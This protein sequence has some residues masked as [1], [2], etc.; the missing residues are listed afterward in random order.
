MPFRSST[1][2]YASC[3][4][5]TLAATQACCP[6]WMD[7]AGGGSDDCSLN[8]LEG[9]PDFEKMRKTSPCSLC[10]R[11]G[12]REV[13]DE[14]TPSFLR[15]TA[16]SEAVFRRRIRSRYNCSVT[17]SFSTMCGGGATAPSEAFWFR[18]L[19]AGLG[20]CV[21]DWS[22]RRA[23]I[24]SAGVFKRRLRLFL[25]AIVLYGR[26]LGVES[27][28]VSSSSG[29]CWR[30]S[31]GEAFIPSGFVPGD[32]IL[33][34]M[35]KPRRGWTTLQF[36]ACVRGLFCKVLGLGCNFAFFRGPCDSCTLL[37]NI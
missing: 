35:S 31:D 13:V 37:Q 29:R 16:V 2:A 3:V 18:L 17:S 24:G 12:G 1:P 32:G 27:A 26:Q 22:G 33:G 28:S 19:A 14:S 10:H 4:R 15:S 23:A 36:T 34:P 5:R 11:G 7:A 20:C 21:V 30:G 9:R 25:P 6:W 8:K